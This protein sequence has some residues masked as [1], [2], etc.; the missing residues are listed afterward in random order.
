MLYWINRI[1][2]GF[3]FRSALY[4]RIKLSYNMIE[5]H[6]R[7]PPNEVSNDVIEYTCVWSYSFSLQNK[8]QRLVSVVGRKIRSNRRD[9]SV[10]VLFF[11]GLILQTRVDLC[12]CN[13]MLID[14]VVAKPWTD[15]STTGE[16][17]VRVQIERRFIFFVPRH[18]KLFY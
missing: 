2:E 7:R 1:P 12:W 18:D 8:N 14:S 15:A 9:N 4:N 16:H 13:V 17:P 5:Y 11:A 6:P 10:G 3:F